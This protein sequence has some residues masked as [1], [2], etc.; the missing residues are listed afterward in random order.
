M[1]NK[2][3]R[4][5]TFLKNWT[6][7]AAIVIGSVAYLTFAYT[8]FLDAAG[9][10]LLPC[11]EV[12][13]PITI[14]FTLF[15]TFSKV[16][17]HL[18]RLRP[19]HFYVLTTQLLLIGALV[20]ATLFLLP[21]LTGEGLGKGLKLLMEAILVCVIAPCAAASPIVT[22]KLGG[23]LTQMTTFV[24]LSAVV[25]SLLIPAI[26]P[27][28][29]PHQGFTFRVTFLLIL[30]RL[31]SVLLLPLLLG[32][33]VRH[34]VKPLYEWLMRTPDLSFYCWAVSLS[35]VVGLTLR[36]IL[37]SPAS[38]FLLGE[39]AFFS[40]LT[41]ITQFAIGRFIGRDANE[42]ICTGQGMFQKNTS[43]AIWIAYVYLSSVA[44]IGAGC[45]VLWQNII[46]SYELWQHRRTS[47]PGPDTATAPT[48]SQRNTR[49]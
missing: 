28:L 17:F 16:D 21:A 37:H 11:F 48:A 46:N 2:G 26:F 13:L 41:A 24:L 23:N 33:I 9:E 32:A 4:V 47:A 45:Y 8:P 30:Q 39:I 44:S 29:E 3:S 7:P 42:K 1:E 5:L 14:F 38:G 22:A 49:L 25:A 12:L 6:L 27:L 31:A 36:N 10:A 40:L 15:I 34:W 18:M 43:L 19:W 35:I 20:L